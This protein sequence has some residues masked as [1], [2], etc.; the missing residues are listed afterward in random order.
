MSTPG[1]PDVV[2]WIIPV[3]VG[4]NPVPCTV[5]VAP[6]D[7]A[8]MVDGVT[9]ITAGAGFACVCAFTTNETDELD[10][11]PGFVTETGKVPAERL[12]WGIANV[13]DVFDDTV[14][15]FGVVDKE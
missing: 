13:I 4:I 1:I 8:R 15:A 7:P 14:S 9:L 12:A 2:D 6:F 10:A 5:T 3:V 11:V